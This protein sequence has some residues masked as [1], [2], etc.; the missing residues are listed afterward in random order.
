MQTVALAYNK[1]RTMPHIDAFA[2]LC[3]D[4]LGP[5]VRDLPRRLAAGE[6]APGSTL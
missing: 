5:R 6:R 1:N 4:E 2:T 3:H